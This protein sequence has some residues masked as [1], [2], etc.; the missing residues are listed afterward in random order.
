MTRVFSFEQLLQQVNEV[1]R[2]RFTTNFF[3]DKERHSVWIANGD[4]LTEMV[5]NTLFIIRLGEDFCN[6]FYSSTTLEQFSVDLSFFLSLHADQ[7]MMFDV[8]GRDNQCQLLVEDMKRLGGKVTTSLVRMTR[9]SDPL[10]YL[11]DSNI[12]KATETDIPQVS[13]LLHAYFNA[14]TEQIPYVEEL[15]SY[16]SQGHVLLYEDHGQVAGF[17]IYEKTNTTLYLRYW[18]TRP[19]FRNS[20]VGSRLFR[21]F[22]EE[23]K[24]TKRQLLWVI[25]TNENAIKRY[26][27]YGFHEENMF[28][29]VLQFN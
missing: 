7:T 27:H 22:F 25:R 28:D 12:R 11:P 3:L 8:V 16:A 13:H 1:R 2:Q 14:R 9:I 17:L 19:E 24:D 18:F 23:G 4:C 10:D 26:R 5:G 15:C 21:Q 20:G 29:Y 6:V